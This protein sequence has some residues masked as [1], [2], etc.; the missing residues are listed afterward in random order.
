MN[1]TDY[2]L[3]EKYR[4]KYA[5]IYEITYNSCPPYKEP[6][7][8]NIAPYGSVGFSLRFSENTLLRTYPVGG[9]SQ[10]IMEPAGQGK[11]QGRPE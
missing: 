3:P 8:G 4:R 1:L 2:S 11:N 6:E 9:G 10:M 7:P 5:V